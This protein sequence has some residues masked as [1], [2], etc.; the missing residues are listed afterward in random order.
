MPIITL[1][2][3]RLVSRVNNYQNLYI[4]LIVKKVLWL[5]LKYKSIDI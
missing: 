4:Y 3:N 5:R 2:A 1:R